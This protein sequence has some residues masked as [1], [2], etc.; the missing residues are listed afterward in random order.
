M[1]RSLEDFLLSLSPEDRLKFIE[2]LF[3]NLILEQKSVRKRTTLK[4]STDM[5]DEEVRKAIIEVTGMSTEEVPEIHFKNELSKIKNH[6]SS[7]EQIIKEY[8]TKLGTLPGVSQDKYEE[9]YDLGRFIDALNNNLNIYVPDEVLKFPDF[10]ILLEERKIGVEHT[11]LIDEETKAVF[12]AAKYFIEKAKHLIEDELNYLSKTVNIFIDYNENV[13]DQKNFKNRRFSNDQKNK[14]IQ[15]IAN[16]IKSELVGGNIAKPNFISQIRIT[17]NKDSRIDLGLAESY[18]VISEFTS[19]LMHRINAKEIKAANYRTIASLNE[20]WLLIVVD[21]I[22]SF[23]GFDLATAQL[24]QI[25][26]SNFDRILLFEKFIGRIYRL[27]EK[28]NR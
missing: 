14:V 15:I 2:K 21:D 4:F 20:L 24:P 28:S 5:S 7:V 6:S 3:A 17:P 1:N 19:M 26:E 27:F 12:K 18:F 10:I 25:K 23:S 11:R 8:K 22:N 16:Y 9:L 13:I